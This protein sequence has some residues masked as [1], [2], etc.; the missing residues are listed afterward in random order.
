MDV[1]LKEAALQQAALLL[2]G[3]ECIVMI[4]CPPK[5][6]NN[7]SFVIC[8]SLD[9]SLHEQLIEEGFS[10]DLLNILQPVIDSSPTTEGNLSSLASPCIQCLY[11]I[12]NSS[13]RLRLQLGNNA[14]FLLDI[15]KGQICVVSLIQCDLSKPVT[16][17]TIT[18][19]LA[20]FKFQNITIIHILYKA[21]AILAT[22]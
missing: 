16:L 19:T 14:D 3:K 11:L 1:T 15:F 17:L 13:D 4:A 5:C 9:Q 20:Q 6:Y 2:Q 10:D 21:A 18:C 8:V 12:A 22:N 7:I